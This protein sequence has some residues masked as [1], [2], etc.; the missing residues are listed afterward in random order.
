VSDQ[1]ERPRCAEEPK[2]RTEEKLGVASLAGWIGHPAVQPAITTA[3]PYAAV[4][5]APLDA[6]LEGQPDVIRF[7]WGAFEMGAVEPGWIRRGHSWMLTPLE[8][9]AVEP[10]RAAVRRI[11]RVT[12]RKIAN[13]GSRIDPEWSGDLAV[14]AELAVMEGVLGFTVPW[15]L[16]PRKLAEVMQPPGVSA[17]D[18][19]A[20]G[21]KHRRWISERA[22]R[23][24]GALRRSYEQHLLGEPKPPAPYAGGGTR[25]S[26][27]TTL[28][29][30]DAMRT[31]LAAFPNV[32]AS[33]IR[34]SYHGSAFRLDLKTPASP[35]GYLRH[36]LGEEHRCPADSTLTSDLN[37]LR[38]E[39]SEK[40]GE[41]PAG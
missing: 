29:R 11:A 25:S 22:E 15:H 34:S 27:K 14:I 18:A 20:R 40:A 41:K 32:T 26:R 35:G 33:D 8:R 12:A 6:H 2:F 13:A 17:I 28:R 5:V 30:L 39:T 7:C 21:T 38:S 1:Q 4:A 31:V 10:A 23:N 37:F 9:T 24:A 36:L 3:A 19:D 16:S